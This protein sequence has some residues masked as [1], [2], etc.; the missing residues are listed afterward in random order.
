MSYYQFSPDWSRRNGQLGLTPFPA[1]DG[2]VRSWFDGVQP[3]EDVPM[4]VDRKVTGNINPSN[5]VSSFDPTLYKWEVINPSLFHWLQLLSQVGVQST[6][7][8]LSNL[9]DRG[10]SN[11]D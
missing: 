9:E 7:S 5:R 2:W 4:E 11:V 1:S 8:D 3:P 10:G 6:I